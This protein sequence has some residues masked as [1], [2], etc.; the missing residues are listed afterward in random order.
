MRGTLADMQPNRADRPFV[1]PPGYVPPPL[2]REV[3][4][5]VQWILDAAARRI[6]DERLRTQANESATPPRTPAKSRR[7]VAR[8]ESKRAARPS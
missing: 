7:S 8:G 5:E 6:L 2:T 1:I 3:A 4:Q